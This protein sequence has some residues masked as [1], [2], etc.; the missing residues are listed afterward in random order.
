MRAEEIIFMADSQLP[1]EQSD[2]VKMSWLRAVEGRIQT[3]I[4]KMKAESVKLPLGGDDEVTLPDTHAEVYL[5]YILAMLEM[6]RGNYAA[7]ATL[8]KRFE[9]AISAYARYYL[10]NRA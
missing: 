3:D 10:R 4:Y 5:F 7:F 6:T 1:N 8:D 2:E 9:E